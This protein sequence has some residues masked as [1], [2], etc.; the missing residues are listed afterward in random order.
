[1][2]FTMKTLRFICCLALAAFAFQLNAQSANIQ[3][4]QN[5]YA[6]FGQGN[7]PAILA[8]L[9]DDCTWMQSGNPSIIPF[10]G[11]FRGKE[12]IG[13]KFFGVVPTAIQILAFEPRDFREADNVVI[14]FVH[15]HGKGIATGKEYDSQVEMHWTFNAQGLV[16]GFQSLGDTSTL[17]AA[18]TK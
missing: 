17:E 11:T 15:I 9:T 8:S 13:N 4:V 16:T 18:L 3:T 1:T 6:A 14:C 5:N 10:A 12:E 7:I 2:I